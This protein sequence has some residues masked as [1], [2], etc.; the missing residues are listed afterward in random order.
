MHWIYK[1]YFSY[2]NDDDKVYHDEDLLIVH[3]T[4]KDNKFLTDDDIKGLENETDKYFYQVY[5]LGKWGILGAVIYKNWEMS[6]LTELKKTADNLRIGHDFGYSNDESATIFCHLD[7]KKKIIYVL[8]EIYAKELSNEELAKLIKE[9]ISK[10]TVVYCDCAEPKSIKKLR[11]LRVNAYG[12]KK[13]PDSISHGIK[14]IQGFKIVI[15]LNCQNFKNEISQYKWKENKNGEILP[16]PV[17][18]N[19]HLCDSL[20]Y[21]LENDMLNQESIIFV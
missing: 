18:K 17:G 14:F 9:K 10:N 11:E 16:I 7:N 3:S 4:Y 5:T 13:G 1:E 2:W 15:D 8:D 12:V 21:C 20:R 6:D 19:D